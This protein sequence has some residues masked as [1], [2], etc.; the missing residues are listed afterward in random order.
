MLKL[1]SPLTWAALAVALLTLGLSYA[2]AATPLSF[3]I[4][5]PSLVL[6]LIGYRTGRDTFFDSTFLFTFALIAVASFRGHNPALLVAAALG[7]IVAWDLRAFRKRLAP[8]E[9]VGEQ[10]DL[11]RLHLQTLLTLIIVTVI[12]SLVIFNAS[13]DIGLWWSIL[14]GGI[15]V[16]GVSQAIR[17]LRE[18]DL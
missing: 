15:L 6:W 11:L 16:I 13:L 9:F 17:F 12:I 14:L 1:L 7:I 8:Y 2:I 4:V 18:G 3:L 5:I 10:L